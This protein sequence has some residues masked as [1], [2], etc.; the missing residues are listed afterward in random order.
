MSKDVCLMSATSAGTPTNAPEAPAVIPVI[1]NNKVWIPIT[2]TE[3]D[4]Q[5]LRGLMDLQMRS[6]IGIESQEGVKESEPYRD[7]QHP[8]KKSHQ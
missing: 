4:L 2:C 3:I 7:A 1:I 6:M 8:K 5:K